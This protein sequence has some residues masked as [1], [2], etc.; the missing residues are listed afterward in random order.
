MMTA[1]AGDEEFRKKITA[2]LLSGTTLIVLDNVEGPLLASSLAAALT[3]DTWSDRILGQSAMVTLPQ[4]VTW[5]ATGN[6][7]QLGGDLARRCY[8]IRLDAHTSR[9]WQRTGFR[10][11]DLLGWVSAQ[12]G[13]LVHALLTLSQAWYHAGQPAAVTPILGSFEAWTRTIGGI[14][15]H[16]GVPGFL[17]NLGDLYAQVDEGDSGQWTAFLHAWLTTYGERL[18]AVAELTEDLLVEGSAVRDVLPDDLADSLPT[19]DG[20]TGRFRRK[21][22]HA[23][24][25]RVER[26]FGEEDVYLARSEDRHKKVALWRVR[27]GRGEVRGSHSLV[28]P[29]PPSSLPPAADADAPPM[30]PHT[31]LTLPGLALPGPDEDP[32]PT[33]TSEATEG[34]APSRLLPSGLTSS[35][36]CPPAAYRLITD[37]TNLADALQAIGDCRVLGV[38]TETTGLD[39]LT[40]RLRLLQLAAPGWPVLVID[41]WTI[42]EGARVPLQRLLTQPST[43]KVFH[44]A[45]F[46]LQFLRQAG[47]PVQGLLGDTMLAAQLLDAGLQTRP[48][49]LADLVDRFLHEV[50]AKEAQRS[51]WGGT[52]TPDQLQYAATDAAILLRLREVLL[53]A[54]QAAGLAEAATLEWRCLPAVAEMELHGMGIDQAHLT[55]LR[56]QLQTETA[57]AAMALTALLPP[58]WETDVTPLFA[59][60]AAAPINLDS[61]TQLLQALQRLGVPVTSTTRG[62]LAPLAASVTVVQ[63][64]LEYRRVR[65]ALTFTEALPSHVHPATGRLH[66]TYWQLGAATGRFACSDPNVQQIPRTAAFRQC[67]IAPPG[68]L[69]VIADYSQIELRVMAELSGDARMLAAYQ[70]GEDLHTLTAALLLDKPH[71]AG[72]P[73]RTPG[74]QGGEFRVALCH[75]R[76]G[77]TGLCA[78]Q[79]RR[80]PDGG[81]GPGIPSGLLYRLCRRGAVAGADPC[82]HAADG[83]PDPAWP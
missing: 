35:T 51:D 68:S 65:K 75:E 6:N 64:V 41:L 1:P 55:T 46:D 72:H 40:D 60:A 24:R 39:P 48:Q 10:H 25:Q 69:L 42:P 56:Q 2:T 73:G 12:R 82:R 63:A 8:W 50:L 15:T 53:P 21:L 32:D 38:D 34:H 31:S 33:C 74:R 36:A 20:E 79:L 80:D 19:R 43:V 11:P 78:A 83:E 52:L 61:P 17:A 14:L 27:R 67:F 29:V 9:P 7:L 18:I 30:T 59:A 16:V 49:S 5:V 4:H 47:L 22:G 3:A 62:A 23:L 76:R 77:I 26:R 45:K 13:D 54:L 28:P 66:A 44:N 81:S 37:A 70:A 58:A 57:Q 71:G